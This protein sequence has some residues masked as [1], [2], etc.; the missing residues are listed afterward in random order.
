MT[1]PSE[2]VDRLWQLHPHT[3]TFVAE[4]IGSSYDS[5]TVR[6]LLL[7]LLGH[8]DAI[9]REGVVLGLRRHV[10]TMVRVELV[11]VA[12]HDPSAAVR[13]EAMGALSIG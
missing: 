9:V 3:L 2:D 8:P 10:D 11:R 5:V 13:L 12:Q 1:G 6:A 4:A 7:P